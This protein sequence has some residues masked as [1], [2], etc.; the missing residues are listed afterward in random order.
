[1]SKNSK[2]KPVSMEKQLLATQFVDSIM[3]RDKKGAEKALS[4]MVNNRIS[5]K[6]RK[7]AQTENL[8]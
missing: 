4:E 6:I 5:A 3:N 1:M 8:I 2:Q 7:V